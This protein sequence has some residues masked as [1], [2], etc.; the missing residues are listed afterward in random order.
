MCFRRGLRQ[1]PSEREDLRCV[2]REQKSYV[3]IVLCACL[4]T[5]GHYGPESRDCRVMECTYVEVC[6]HLKTQS[7]EP[8]WDG[9]YVRQVGGKTVRA[10]W[11]CD[12]NVSRHGCAVSPALTEPTYWDLFRTAYRR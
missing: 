7:C 2:A 4:T 8:L 11:T 5:Q 9:G 10:G 6:T 3:R 1:G 12:A